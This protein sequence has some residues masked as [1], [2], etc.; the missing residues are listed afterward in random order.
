[1]NYLTTLKVVNELHTVAFANMLE[2]VIVSVIVSSMLIFEII[3]M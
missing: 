3:K 2:I 1:M